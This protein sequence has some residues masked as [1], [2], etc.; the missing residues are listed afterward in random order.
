MKDIKAL[1]LEVEIFYKNN[2]KPI[3][4]TWSFE[5]DDKGTFY[6]EA[7]TNKKRY[8]V[9]RNYLHCERNFLARNAWLDKATTCGVFCRGSLQQNRVTL[10]CAWCEKE[11]V[12]NPSKLNNSKHG[13]HFCSRGCK[14]EAQR[15]DGL[16]ELHLPHYKDGTR[17]Y[18]SRAFRY[19]GEK[20]CDC[21]LTFKP[22]L[23]VHHVDG[24][25]L[26]GKLENLEVVCSLHH[27]L[28]HMRQ[29]KS[30]NWVF[31]TKSLTPRDKLGEL[32]KMLVNKIGN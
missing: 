20:C 19:Y 32:K 28:R 2:N 30:N 14:D 24:N 13:L 29:D 18:A 4:A 31:D 17:E 26:N 21:G 9:V 15:L 25:R 3:P 11:I 12:K 8:G 22:L 27:D 5:K 23:S 7:R 1:Q 16:K 10:S 6:L